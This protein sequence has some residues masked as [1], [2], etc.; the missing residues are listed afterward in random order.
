[1]SFQMSF[2]PRYLAAALV[3]LAAAAT[4]RAEIVFTA[5]L[6]HDQET[7]Q[8]AFLTSTGAPRPQ[9]FGEATF[10]LSDDETSLTMS[11]TIFN[12]DVTGTQTPDTF[13]NLAAAHIHAGPTAVLGQNA[14]VVW[15]FFGAPDNDNDPDNLV[16]TPFAADVG[17]TF[18]SV[19]NLNEGN[20][21]TNLTAQIPNL[22]AGLSYINFH[23][24]Q[25]PGGEIRGQLVAV[26]EPAILA[27]MS[28]ARGLLVLSRRKRS[29]K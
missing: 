9:S 25:F 4:A 14:P 6:T 15:G 21:G 28:I 1:M 8:G 19:W 22:L 20:A 7:V 12:I 17:G 18:T 24:V 10:V 11:A 29:R 3:M 27:L 2:Q 23:T 5:T 13:D 16:V 26:P